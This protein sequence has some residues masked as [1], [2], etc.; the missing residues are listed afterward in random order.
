[1]TPAPLGHPQHPE[2][3]PGDTRMPPVGVGGV[4]GGTLLGTPLVSPGQPQ[5]IARVPVPL[6]PHV[7]FGCPQVSPYPVCVSPRDPMALS[8]C[9]Q[10]SPYPVWVSPGDPM[11]P[12]GCPHMSPCPVCV[13]PGDPMTLSVCPQV[14]LCLVW[15]SP[16]D[17]TPCLGVLRCP[18]VQSVCPQ[19]SP[20]PVCVSP[21]VPILVW[22]S[23]GAPMS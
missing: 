13:S 19:V 2:V 22:V 17:P 20:S 5:G 3:T 6:C 10:M 1:M 7:C 18:H 4:W 9:P 8:G 11:A 21:S 15:M 14:S 23:P 12:S 16:G